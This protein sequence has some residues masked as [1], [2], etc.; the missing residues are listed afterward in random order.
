[1]IRAKK[2][3][4]TTKFGSNS[5]GNLIRIITSNGKKDDD[6]YR[7][8]ATRDRRNNS[9][10]FLTILLVICGAIFSFGIIIWFILGWR[11]Q[12]RAD[13]HVESVIN[14]LRTMAKL[15][16]KF[17]LHDSTEKRWNVLSYELIN[18]YCELP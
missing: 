5:L 6:R 4:G 1:M 7:Y 15:D 2:I 18:R 11:R 3:R 8:N 17:D 13:Q 16:S 12:S 9:T 14:E 10:K